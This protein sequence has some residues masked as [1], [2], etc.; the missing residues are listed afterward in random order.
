VGHDKKNCTNKKAI[1]FDPR[2]V[3][4][5][6]SSGS[7]CA[8]FVGLPIDGAKKNSIWVPKALVTNIQ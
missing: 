3:L 2:Y 5:K 6:N 8:K 1:S 4:M 7:V